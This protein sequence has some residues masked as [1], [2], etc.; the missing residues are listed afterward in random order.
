MC[1]IYC[2][3]NCASSISTS[4]PCH[5]VPKSFGGQVQCASNKFRIQVYSD[6]RHYSVFAFFIARNVHYFMYPCRH[7]VTFMP[8]VSVL[9]LYY[10]PSGSVKDPMR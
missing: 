8:R 1:E 9:R 7:M 3:I 6:I 5:L 4:F 2:G 10:S